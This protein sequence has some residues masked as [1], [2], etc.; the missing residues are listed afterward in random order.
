MAQSISS[1]RSTHQNTELY[2]GSGGNLC[3]EIKKMSRIGKVVRI[4]IRGNVV[5]VE[6]GDGVGKIA[7]FGEVFDSGEKFRCW[8]DYEAS[9]KQIE[10]RVGKEGRER[11]VVPVVMYMID[12]V[13]MWDGEEVVVGL[14][15]SGS[16]N[17][18]ET[19]SVYS[20]RFRVRGVPKGMHSRPMIPE[21]EINGHVEQK[22]EK[23]RSCHL[24]V[25]AFGCAALVAVVLLSFWE[26]FVRRYEYDSVTPAEIDI[27]PVDFKY[28]KIGVDVENVFE[29][30]KKEKVVV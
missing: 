26:M 24:G 23:K 12:L 21:S 16:G 28:Q 2:T 30:V 13:E 5:G 25:V 14:S 9:S 8:V 15:S 10:V 3:F 19:V 11:S 1:V 20:W 17:V 27:K 6:I 22:G 18:G 7:T 29:N 4:R